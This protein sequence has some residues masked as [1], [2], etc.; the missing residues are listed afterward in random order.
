MKWN[1]ISKSIQVQK[2]TTWYN[3]KV[4]KEKKN[5]K[6]QVSH[7]YH[8]IKITVFKEKFPKNKRKSQ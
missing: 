8:S 6:E 5:E 1:N 2:L 3:I 4:R 7:R